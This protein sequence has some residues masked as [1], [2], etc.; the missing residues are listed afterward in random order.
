[1][2]GGGQNS[3]VGRGGF[4]DQNIDPWCTVFS[5]ETT[6][7][8]ERELPRRAVYSPDWGVC[9]SASHAHR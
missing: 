6:G 8:G 9:G 4:S 5:I 1:M 7:V 3:I 2:A